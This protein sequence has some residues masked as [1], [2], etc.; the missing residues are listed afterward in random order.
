MNRVTFSLIASFVFLTS[1][2]TT[3]Q[4]IETPPEE[5]HRQLAAGQLLE[6]GDRVR[7]V[8]K[9]EIVHKFRVSEI[10]VTNGLVVG[11]GKQVPIADIVAVETREVSV[12]KT[13]LLV[14]G[15]GYGILALIAITIAPAAIL[16]GG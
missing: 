10:D 11:H 6:P 2:C 1:A 9:D 12:G 15:L 8:T 14:G 13:A 4:P 5:L 3:L 16:A 7:L